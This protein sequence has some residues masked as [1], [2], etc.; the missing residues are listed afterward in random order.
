M[1]LFVFFFAP[2]LIA[3]F[4]NSLCDYARSIAIIFNYKVFK[5][6]DFFQF[7]FSVVFECFTQRIHIDFEL[8]IC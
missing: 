4:S 6:C 2:L 3:I 8:L 5:P 7:W 1:L